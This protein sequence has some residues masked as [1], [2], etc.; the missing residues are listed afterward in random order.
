MKYRIHTFDELVSTN[1]TAS[2]NIYIDGDVIVAKFQSSGRGQ[3]GN[4]WV[5]KGGE[6]LMF[7][8]LLEPQYIMVNQQF[9]ISMA[10]A[11]A[12]RRAVESYGVEGVEVKWPNDIM[13]RGEKI[14]GILIEHF[15]SSAY[16]SRTI[17]G[18]GINVGQTDFPEDA[19][20][21][22]SLHLLGASSATSEEALERFLQ[23]FSEVYN[24]AEEQLLEEYLG[25]LYRRVGEYKF[26]D[27]SGEF[28]ASIHSINPHSGEMTL[29]VSGTNELRSYYFK[30][31]SYL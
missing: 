6:N 12:V 8:L 25:G 1:D 3:R 19:G 27:K 17:V 21:P 2:E 24:M 18:V 29:Q 20:N 7:S 26:E 22:T 10:A 31:V 14:A 16:L 28:E 30:E 11:V 15:F 9:L 13:V 4:K 5:S 23:H